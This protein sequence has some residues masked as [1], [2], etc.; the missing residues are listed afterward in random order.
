MEK[1]YAFI[2]AILITLLIGGNWLFFNA[3]KIFSERE[4]VVI[5]RVIDG[6][7]VELEDGRTIRLENINAE[8]KGRPFSQE[9][10]EFLNK[11]ENKTV[12]MDSDGVG[13]Y[14]RVIGRIYST[15]GE[16]LNL[17]IVEL[18]FAH[19]YIVADEELKEFKEAEKKAQ[20]NQAGIW[21]NS[22]NYGCLNAVINKKDEYVFF[23]NNCGNLNEWTIKDESTKNYKFGEIDYEE[24]I[25]YS[26][27][28][29]NEG[30]E[31]YWDRSG[32]NVWN[33]DK[34][35]IFVRDSDGLLVFYDSYGY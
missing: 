6:D 12:E 26:G 18:G 10:F 24:F 8:E 30:S 13:K 20:E 5:S 23:E 28:G 25:L 1:K 17:K 3:D 34:D 33:N 4:V 22:E 15:S 27:G 14:G 19:S 21:K 9:A 2:L 29:V 31:I 32:G 7:T 16:Y 35:S 11:F